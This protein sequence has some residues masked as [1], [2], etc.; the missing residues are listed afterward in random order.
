MTYR[1]S[2]SGK[3][4]LQRRWLHRVAVVGLLAVGD[5]DGRAAGGAAARACNDG[6]LMRRIPS[7]TVNE[8]SMQIHISLC[9]QGAGAASAKVERFGIFGKC[10]CIS[11]R[12]GKDLYT[13]VQSTPILSFSNGHQ[14]PSNS[15]A[16]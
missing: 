6:K 9:V 13:P 12:E 3:T 4:Y 11:E 2:R 8:S 14:H 15:N 10:T 1:P 5:A 7:R 16:G